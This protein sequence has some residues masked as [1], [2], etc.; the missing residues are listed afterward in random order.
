LQQHCTSPQHTATHCNTLQHTAIDCNSLDTRSLIPAESLSPFR[1]ECT[2]RRVLDVIPYICRMPTPHISASQQLGP[3]CA[4]AAHTGRIKLYNSGF[5]AKNQKMS[6]NSKL[7]R[8]GNGK[9][10]LKTCEDWFCMILGCR[11]VKDNHKAGNLRVFWLPVTPPLIAS[12]GDL[13]GGSP[14]TSVTVYTKHVHVMFN[15]QTVSSLQTL[16]LK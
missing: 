14:S 6:M 4:A 3:H 7:M 1:E 15:Q 9:F 8:D 16:E 5:I 10:R 13:T 11:I 2:R 12:S